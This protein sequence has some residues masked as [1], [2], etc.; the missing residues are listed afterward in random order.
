MAALGMAALGMA[1]LGMAALG[2]MAALAGPLLAAPFAADA[3]QP[4][5]IYRIGILGNVPLTDPGGARLWG[6]FIQGLRD[7]GYVEGRNITIEHL[8]SEGKYEKLPA[9]AAELVRRKVDVIVAPAAQNV[10]AA[11]QATRTIPIVMASVGDPVGDGLVASLAHPGGNVT[12]TSF[13]TSAMIGKQLELLK[14]IAP[15]ETRLAVLVN[16]ANPGHLLALEEA[17]VAAHSLGVQLQAPEA[18]GPNDFERAFAAMT[19]E[20]AGALFVP[21]DGTFLLHLVR[22]TQLAAKTRLP[23][24]YG[25]RGYVD[26]GG[27]AC[28]GPS[29]S[30][31]FRGAAAYVDKIFRGA[32]PGDLPVEQPTKFEF[33]I[34]LKTARALGLSM[35]SSLLQRADQ[36]IE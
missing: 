29:A 8:S 5:R 6:A 2:G 16:P 36:V 24:M 23:A 27:L 3:Q 19:R 33:V 17:K 12:G 10:V 11:K 1:A 32:R 9:L 21:W 13:L 34:N 35:P 31:S 15:R 22:I 7:L 30:E 25:Q 26:A 18:R 14:Q 28:Y 20:H 4:G